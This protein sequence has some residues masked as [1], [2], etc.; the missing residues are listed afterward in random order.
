MPSFSNN[1]YSYSTA[2]DVANYFADNRQQLYTSV[3][4]KTDEITCLEKVADI[5][6]NVGF[7]AQYAFTCDV[8]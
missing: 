7:D 1:V 3:A 2:V 4:Y 5:V 8:C 6:Y